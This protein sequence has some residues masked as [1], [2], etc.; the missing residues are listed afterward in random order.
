VNGQAWKFMRHVLCETAGVLLVLFS[1]RGQAAAD[2]LQNLDF[3][4]ANFVP[5]P[6]FSQGS[7]NPTNALPGWTALWGTQRRRHNAHAIRWRR[8]RSHD[9]GY[10][11]RPAG[12]RDRET[13]RLSEL[14]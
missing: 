8:R 6:S 10:D 2:L 11:Q 7:V 5:A 9:S 13:V 1:S 3:E 12:H 4:S 14:A